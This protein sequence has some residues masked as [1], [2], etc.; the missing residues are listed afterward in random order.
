MALEAGHW[1]VGLTVALVWF[2]AQL[3]RRGSL[4]CVQCTPGLLIR[5]MDVLC[6]G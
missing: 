2:S 6:F 5:E 3:P 4:A 1:R